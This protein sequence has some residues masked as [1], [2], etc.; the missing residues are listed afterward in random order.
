MLFEIRGRLGDNRR[1]DY[2]SEDCFQWTEQ[3]TKSSVY[4][5]VDSFFST[6]R[7]KDALEEE[8]LLAEPRCKLV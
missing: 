4:S 8:K 5:H 6:F 3:P 1:P 7:K 2:Q